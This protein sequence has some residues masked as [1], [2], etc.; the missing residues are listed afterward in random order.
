MV[1]NTLCVLGILFGGA[2]W[3]I[4]TSIF[5]YL[6]FEYC[7]SPSSPASYAGKIFGIAVVF[8]CMAALFVVIGLHGLRL[9]PG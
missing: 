5:G 9:L 2:L 7:M 6:T 4:A 3:L 8:L 1:L